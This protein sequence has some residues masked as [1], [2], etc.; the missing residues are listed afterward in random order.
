EITRVAHHAIASAEPDLISLHAG[1]AAGAALQRGSAREAADLFAVALDATRDVEDGRA[2]RLL[3]GLS[4]A[5]SRSGSI[6]ASRDRAEEAV[7]LSRR[8]GDAALCGEALT[9]AAKARW[10]AGDPP[11]AREAI[12]EAVD[13]LRASGPSLALAEALYVAASQ[14]MFARHHLDALENAR[15]AGGVAG[16]LGADAIRARALQVEGTTQI[17]TGDVE[18]GRRLVEESLVDARRRRD[19]RL[20]TDGLLMLGSGLGEVRSYGAA[21]EALDQLDELCDRYDQNYA[22]AYGRAWRARILLELGRWDDALA[23]SMEVDA[24]PAT[25]PVA[26]LTSLGVIARLRIRRG[27]PRPEEALAATD[28][29]SRMELQH[30][31]PALCAHA[32]L[33]WLHGRLEAGR[34][35]LDEA[36]AAAQLTDSAW[37]RGE[38]GVWRWRLGADPGPTEFMAEPCR[39]EVE[40][41]WDGAAT[42]W[43]HLG[44]PYEEALALLGGDNA[45]LSRSLAIQ[46]RLGARPLAARTRARLRSEGRPVPRPSRAST[47][48]HPDGLTQREV[49]VLRL[50]QRGMSNPQI[51]DQLVLS[52][53][54]VEHHVS[55]V[56]AKRGVATR[57]ELGEALTQD[58]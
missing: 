54:T 29:T 16:V 5:L 41:D 33:H 6:E 2:A 31:W 52:R 25:T 30:R 20:E 45:A 4:E 55:S 36:H 27:D 26:R 58:G 3:Q 1:A 24:G 15:E 22:S 40:G 42:A 48:E 53:R 8:L 49:E 47:R 51:A 12:S 46:D 21:L 50:V 10:R 9:Q 19:V 44:C 37:A 17:V 39:L 34:A 7:S 38:I 28:D 14:D 11:A 23:A 56:L 18:L 57:A 13:T 32:E 35:C 43:R